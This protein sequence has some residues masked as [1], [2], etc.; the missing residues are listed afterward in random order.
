LTG[1]EGAAEGLALAVPDGVG[2]RLRVA[3]ALREAVALRERVG[4]GSALPD[5]EDVGSALPERLGVGS[6]LPDGEDVDSALPERVGD[7]GLAVGE[8]EAVAAGDWDAAAVPVVDAATL[9]VLL[10][11][12]APLRLALALE[13]R[14][15]DT[16]GE[17]VGDGEGEG[18]TVCEG[19]RDAEGVTEADGDAEAVSEVE[20]EDEGEGRGVDART[21]TSSSSGP[22]DPSA[23]LVKARVAVD[24]G[25]VNST[26]WRA[27]GTTDQP[28]ELSKWALNVPTAVPLMFTIK[29][30]RGTARL[31]SQLPSSAKERV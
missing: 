8:G 9:G 12:L 31:S 15:G 4:V 11:L 18:E 1:V 23:R 22:H 3:G 16:E 14:V 13:L 6:A 26:V 5:G 28:V 7:T 29:V 30:R 19:D 2:V 24:S 17:A 25:G 21:C 20:G 10:G 27:H